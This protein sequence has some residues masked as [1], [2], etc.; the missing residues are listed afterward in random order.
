MLRAKQLGAVQPRA[1]LQ[2]EDVSTMADVGGEAASLPEWQL[3]RAYA[4]DDTGKQ[5]VPVENVRDLQRRGHFVMPVKQAYRTRIGLLQ[6]AVNGPLMEKRDALVR[7]NARLDGAIEAVR[8]AKAAVARDT[9]TAC[10]EILARLDA[11]ER[12]KLALL[13]GDRAEIRGDIERAQALADEVA[14]V[15]QRLDVLDFLGKERLL[16]DL[17]ARLVA[18]PYKDTIDAAASSDDFENEAQAW[19]GL[20]RKYKALQELVDVK[21]AMIAKLLAE[22]HAMQERLGAAMEEVAEA[23]AAASEGGDA[24]V[25]VSDA[26]GA[27]SEGYAPHA[28]ASVVAAAAPVGKAGAGHGRWLMTV[29]SDGRR[30]EIYHDGRTNGLVATESGAEETVA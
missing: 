3:D 27:S 10:D 13:E 26:D 6:N 11:T 12:V 28:E 8:N 1:L 21:D 5:V 29:E 25:G 15:G 7:H 9:R 17:C 16:S 24:S 22:R 20:A 19:R 4:W 14:T 23:K 18:K 30:L 2:A